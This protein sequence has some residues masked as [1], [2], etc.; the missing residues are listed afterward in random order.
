MSAA[1]DHFVSVGFADAS[2]SEIAANAGVAEGTVYRFFESKRALLVAVIASWFEA[3]I[4]D[5]SENL[6]GIQDP[7]ERLRFL[8][9][10]HA[11]IIETDPA[12]CRLFFDQIRSAEDYVNSPVHA[13]NRDYA[14]FVVAALKDGVRSGVFQRGLNVALIRDAIFGALEHHATG[15]LYGGAKFNTA[16]VTQGLLALVLT[17]IAHKD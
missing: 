8:V 16:K 17:G 15:Y 14:D 7:T 11:R 3:L 12:L 10:R 1:R 5:V 9:W 13:L 4:K 6:D 2:V